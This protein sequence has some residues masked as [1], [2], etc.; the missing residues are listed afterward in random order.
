MQAMDLYFSRETAG[1]LSG[2]SD[3][4]LLEQLSQCCALAG[5]GAAYSSSCCNSMCMQCL[6]SYWLRSSPSRLRVV[7]IVLRFDLQMFC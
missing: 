4:P 7:P 6:A 5:H 1:A 3:L 2:S